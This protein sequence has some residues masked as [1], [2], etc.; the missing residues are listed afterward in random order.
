MGEIWLAALIT[1]LVLALLLAS[2]PFTEKWDP[3]SDTKAPE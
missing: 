3:G 1:L 2:R